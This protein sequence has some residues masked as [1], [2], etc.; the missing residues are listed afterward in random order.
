MKHVNAE[1]K[2]HKDLRKGKKNNINFLTVENS[3]TDNS[4][5]RQGRV[6]SLIVWK[7]TKLK[8][9]L[10]MFNLLN[11]FNKENLQQEKPTANETGDI[12]LVAKPATLPFVP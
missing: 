8:K 11:M 10:Y 9:L 5:T 4:P 1:P 3:S 6:T 12:S 2:Q 7:Q